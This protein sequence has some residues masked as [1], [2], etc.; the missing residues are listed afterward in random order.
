MMTMLALPQQSVTVS[1]GVNSAPVANDDV[2]STELNT[3]TTTDVLA[4]DVDVD[5]TLNASGVTVTTQPSRGTVAVNADGTITYTPET[6][7]VGADSYEYQVC[8]NDGAC[9]TYADDEGTNGLTPVD[10]CCV[11][12]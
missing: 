10:A 3:A 7:Y 8:D 5:G 6:D 4:N 12:K 9:D 2:I 1:V 11:C